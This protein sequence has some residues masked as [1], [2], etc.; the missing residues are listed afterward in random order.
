MNLWLKIG[1]FVK[2]DEKLVNQSVATSTSV[3]Y[4][5]PSHGGD[6]GS[7]IRLKALKK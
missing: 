1:S 5:E 7:F 2:S 6:V 3:P 4:L